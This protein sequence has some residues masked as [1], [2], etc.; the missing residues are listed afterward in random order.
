MI[1][2]NSRFRSVVLALTLLVAGQVS[3]FAW[4]T[5]PAMPTMP[6]MPISAKGAAF[7]F[8]CVCYVRLYTKPS[9][10]TLG[11]KSED[12][13]DDVKNVMSSLNIFDAELYANVIKMFDKWMIG[14]K[15]TILDFTTRTREENGKVVAVKDKKL[16][17]TAFGALGLFDAYVLQQI[18]KLHTVSG[19]LTKM[20]GLYT[21][22]NN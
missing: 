15:L 19:N 14:R 17:C 1:S 20:N 16:K 6:T 18:D 8:A 7:I 4:P 12:F 2:L 13:E 21:S 5:M 22:C 9:C 11:Y 3:A 10:D